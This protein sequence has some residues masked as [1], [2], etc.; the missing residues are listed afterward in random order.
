M[1]LCYCSGRTEQ[2][3]LALF[4]KMRKMMMLIQPSSTTIYTVQRTLTI[5]DRKTRNC[6]CFPLKLQ[7]LF[8]PN[9]IFKEVQLI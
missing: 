9:P 3:K 8:S 6:D 1:N 2:I 5:T 7:L 4:F